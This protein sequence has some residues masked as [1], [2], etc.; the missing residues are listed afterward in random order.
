[1]S[2]AMSIAR[3]VKSMTVRAEMKAPLPIRGTMAFL[4]AVA[5]EVA[6]AVAARM[7]FT[8][9][10]R[11]GGAPGT[12][13]GVAP[14][15]FRARANGAR[16]ECWSYGRGPAV[17]L[18]HGWGGIAADWSALAERLVS[19]GRRVVM[20][21]M[22]G[23]GL[24]AGRQSSLPEMAR[25]IHAVAWEASA[26]PGGGMEPLHAVVGH[27]FGGAAAAVAVRD[28]LLTRSLALVA[29]VAYPMSFV[30]AAADSLGLTPRVRRGL[31]R[32]VVARVGGDLSRIDVVAAVG[33]C[34]LPG[35]VVH[36]RGDAR[37]PWEQGRALAE[38][39]RGAELVTTTGLG[40]RGVLR[41]PAVL[42]MLAAH[43][44]AGSRAAS[45]SSSSTVAV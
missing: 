21:D 1:M 26:A 40:H 11:A 15:A 17:L 27:S 37:V 6:A 12:L 10:R 8:P 30:A 28:G 35:L 42:Q 33:G 34:A 44:D 23:H 3:P 18:V 45:S 24:S 38:A 29:P 13:A 14:E 19:S 43:V 39:W 7:F 22:P 36:D 2:E 9:P 31:E 4:G 20:F 25:A 5:P 32:R 41:D 16:I